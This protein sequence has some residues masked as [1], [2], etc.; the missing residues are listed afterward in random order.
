MIVV[1]G[2]TG[3]VGAHIVRQ[4]LDAGE[5][6]RVM[7]RN[8]S[9]HS[10]PDQVEVVPGDLTQPETLPPALAGADRAFVFPVHNEGGAFLQAA[11]QAGLQHVAAVIKRGHALHTYVDRQKAPAT[12][13]GGRRIRAVVDVCPLRARHDK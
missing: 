12:G 13:A 11:R 9:K 7:T 4:L 1:T 8:P 10:F 2:G 3:N 5:K 6:V